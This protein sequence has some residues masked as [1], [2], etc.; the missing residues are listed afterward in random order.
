MSALDQT[1]E[2]TLKMVSFQYSMSTDNGHHLM[3]LN[4]VY[5]TPAEPD[6]EKALRKDARGGVFVARVQCVLNV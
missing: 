1:E 6:C 5:R 4:A 3:R 2:L